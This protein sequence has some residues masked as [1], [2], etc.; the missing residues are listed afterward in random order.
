MKFEEKVNLLIIEIYDKIIKYID[1]NK[2][3][4]D[5]FYDYAY[6]NL[7]NDKQIIYILEKLKNY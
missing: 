6:L 1:N 4:D 3:D 5:I 2:N 7:N